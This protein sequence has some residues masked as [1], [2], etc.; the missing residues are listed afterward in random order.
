MAKSE[1]EPQGNRGSCFCVKEEAGSV[2]DE[3]GGRFGGNGEVRRMP[4][5]DDRFPV[6]ERDPQRRQ[7]D[8]LFERE[9]ANVE[10]VGFER[11]SVVALKAGV[12]E[13]AV[14][15]EDLMS[16]RDVGIGDEIA[17]VVV[18]FP[19][20]ARSSAGV[21]RTLVERP[22]SRAD[23]ILGF[24]MHVVVVR[25]VEEVGERDEGEAVVGVDLERSARDDGV[26]PEEEVEGGRK[27]VGRRRR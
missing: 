21:V 13:W 9:R 10:R 16:G 2:C 27:G 25:V 3:E 18:C 6:L 8:D 26:G 4:V 14:C 5:L 17:D 19:F 24:E 1:E 22:A 7:R 20:P 11:E 12:R 23:G 15:V